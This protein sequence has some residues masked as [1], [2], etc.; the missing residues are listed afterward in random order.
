M[1]NEALKTVQYGY[2]ETPAEVIAE[3][4]GDWADV[5]SD[6]SYDENTEIEDLVYGLYVSGALDRVLMALKVAAEPFVKAG[7]KPSEQGTARLRIDILREMGI[8]EGS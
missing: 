3:R 8:E 7:V 2:G 5:L 1:N 4:I 6:Q